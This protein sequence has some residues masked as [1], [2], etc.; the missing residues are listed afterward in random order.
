VRLTAVHGTANAVGFAL[1]GVLGWR[2]LA[3]VRS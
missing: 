1:L 2:R 3:A